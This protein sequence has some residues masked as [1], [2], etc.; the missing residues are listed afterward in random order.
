MEEKMKSVTI[1]E[2]LETKKSVE[3]LIDVRETYEYTAGHVPSSKNIPMSEIENRISEIKTG[4]YIICQSGARSYQICQW[5]IGQ[6]I[7]VINVL[8]GTCAYS[9][10]LEY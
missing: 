9:G 3:N 7:E 4:D 2:L 10:K 6:G 8:G 1:Q 5:L